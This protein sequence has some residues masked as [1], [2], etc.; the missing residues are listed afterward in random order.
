M[1]FYFF[2]KIIFF[3][4]NADYRNPDYDIFLDSCF[5]NR[6]QLKPKRLTTLNIVD[7]EAIK[8]GNNKI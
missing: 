5:F 4:R 2:A 3:Y 7:F 1:L 6:F 8:T